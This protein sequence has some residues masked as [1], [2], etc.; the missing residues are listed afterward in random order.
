M[1]RA[2]AFF[3]LLAAAITGTVWLANHP[4]DVVIDWQ[5][6]RI[7]TSLALFGLALVLACVI[8]A[9]L[10]A[11]W[12]GIRHFPGRLSGRL[13]EGRQRR[14]VRALTDGMVALAAGD[15]RA[16]RRAARHSLALLDDTPL[17]LLL[18]AQ[19]AQL[20]GDDDGARTYF[21]AMAEDEAG[22][23]LGLR[24]LIALAV[25]AGDGE[26]AAPL[27][28]R[29]RKIQG[30]A[31]WL[32]SAELDLLIAERKWPEIA[33]A[34]QRGLKTKAIDASQGALKRA[35]ALL[36]TA[37]AAAAGGENE[38]A[39]AWAEKAHKQGPSLVPAS[40]FLATLLDK[41]GRKRRAGN[42]LYRAWEATPHPELAAA[43]AT[44][45][46][47]AGDSLDRV[48]HLRKLY[49]AAP[50]HP[51]SAI[52]LARAALDARLWGEARSRLAPIVETKQHPP[53]R[54]CL[55]MAEL[56]EQQHGDLTAA[57]QW[58]ERAAMSPPEPAWVCGGCGS[59]SPQ[60]TALC[61]NC[62]AFAALS[63]HVPGQGGPA[64]LS[65]SGPALPT[66]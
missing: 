51:E 21:A 52:A 38:A 40:T 14:G 58:F 57:R 54:A 55:L 34:L 41:A 16:A 12:Q 63:W 45:K 37:R 2:F 5:G 44:L 11:L 24:G 36:E 61:E 18:A 64:R 47:N 17:T 26:E 43:Y 25:R 3:V 15:G 59:A 10:F 35:T 19:A 23:F 65:S 50:D 32:L 7:E 53:R 42:V 9:L 56:E 6:Y 4:G 46:A 30:G 33:E 62:G 60:W 27:I 8:A 28:E 48:K 13:R 39:L 22:A 29:A 66:P 20:A 49:D 1:I 31:P